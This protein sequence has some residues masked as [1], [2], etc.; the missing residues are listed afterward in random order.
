MRCLTCATNFDPFTH[1]NYWSG[2]PVNIFY[3]NESCKPS[4]AT[5]HE[6][7]GADR[8]APRPVTGAHR[9]EPAEPA[10]G[11]DPLCWHYGSSDTEPLIPVKD[12]PIK[13]GDLVVDR[14]GNE[15]QVVETRWAA[16]HLSNGRAVWNSNVTVIPGR[17]GVTSLGRNAHGQATIHRANAL[18][19]I[20]RWEDLDG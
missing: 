19:V 15:G 9:T 3:C 10:V 13:V 2:K 6:R 17:V 20:T 16:Q 14:D 4:G 18:T 12:W 7:G 5:W 8:P 11:V 1:W